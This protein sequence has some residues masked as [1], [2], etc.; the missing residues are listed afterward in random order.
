MRAYS[1]AARKA[2]LD[3][4]GVA[5]A[6]R[7]AWTDL[8]IKRALAKSPAQKEREALAK[9]RE[10]WDQLIATTRHHASTPR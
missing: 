7:W 5:E 10:N 6:A 1:A 8:D 9:D 3:Q 2:K 4:L